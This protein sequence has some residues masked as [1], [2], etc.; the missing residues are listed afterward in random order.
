M[1]TAGIVDFRTI[2]WEAKKQEKESKINSL[3]MPIV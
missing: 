2:V 3:E 1:K